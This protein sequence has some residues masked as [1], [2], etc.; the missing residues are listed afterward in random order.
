MLD[1]IKNILNGGSNGSA[2]QPEEKCQKCGNLLDGSNTYRL[3]GKKVCLDC[4]KEYDR[5]NV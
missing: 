3:D 1:F 5:L 4:W 2:R